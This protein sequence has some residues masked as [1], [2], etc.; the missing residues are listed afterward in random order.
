[1]TPGR[2]IVLEGPS[3]AGKSTVAASVADL[4]RSAGREVEA[5]TEPT[6]T[7]FGAAV[8]ALEP[9]IPGRALALAVAADRLI[10]VAQ[11]ITPQLAAGR[12]IVCDRYL[13]S[14]LVLQRLDGVA[15]DE[16]LA[17]NAGIPVPTLVA[18]VAPPTA[19]VQSRL[20]ERG[21][22]SRLER[23]GGA[24]VETAYYL[25]AFKLL[26]GRGWRQVWLDDVA[27]TPSEIAAAVL[28][29]LPKA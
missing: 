23:L 1:M 27:R 3:G 26:G 24:E 14:S 9:G 8:R 29:E 16:V 4:L 6:A 10:H 21:A 13:P 5:T 15:V 7:A 12:D 25:D 28:G 17:M 11:T 18:Y 19:I 20:E 22:V 2:F